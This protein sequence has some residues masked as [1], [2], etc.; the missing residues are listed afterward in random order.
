[1]KEAEAA[2][3]TT[4][5]PTDTTFAV[6]RDRGKL[7]SNGEIIWILQALLSHS[8][9]DKL[10]CG[11]VAAVAVEFGVSRHCVGA[12]LK[13]GQDSS[14]NGGQYLDVSHKKSNCG[15]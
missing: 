1:M 4:D 13:R 2:K 9:A 7:L 10:H 3:D 12:I 5:A 6:R 15:R 14:N 11:A 8:S